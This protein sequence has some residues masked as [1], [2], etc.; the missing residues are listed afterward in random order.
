M[1]KTIFIFLLLIF[2]VPKF[3]YAEDELS[4]HAH[5]IDG[6]T[7]KIGETHIR[8]Y[9]IDAP[10]MQQECYSE[11]SDIKC[12]EIASRVL[13]SLVRGQ[14]ITCSSIGDK[15]EYGRII[16]KCH[17]EKGIDISQEMVNRGYALA[18][19]KYSLDYVDEEEIARKNNYGIWAWNF[20]NPWDW[21]RGMR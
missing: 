18:Y 7:L 5:I 19:Q 15:D 12:G 21:R 2:L 16:G 9:G 17:N 4:G 6:D 3:L 13:Y 8:L 11:Y 14:I 10:E 20:V 1:K